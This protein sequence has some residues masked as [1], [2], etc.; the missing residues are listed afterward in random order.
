MGGSDW[1]RT[2]E[3]VARKWHPLQ[4]ERR[5]PVHAHDVINSLERDIFSHLGAVLLSEIE[6]SLLLSVLR[7]IENRGTIE[8]VREIKQRVAAIYR[9]ANAQGARLENPAVDI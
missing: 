7:R 4:I 6:K 3:D 1:A 2:L 5:K 9:Y 8:T